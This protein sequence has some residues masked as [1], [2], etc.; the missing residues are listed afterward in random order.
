MAKGGHTW[1]GGDRA[2]SLLHSKT[3]L[4]ATGTP[5]STAKSEPPQLAVCVSCTNILCKYYNT[6]I[7]VSHSTQ[8]GPQYFLCKWMKSYVKVGW[9]W[10][11][12]KEHLWGLNYV[13]FKNHPCLVH[14][15]TRMKNK[16]MDCGKS[17][18]IT[19]WMCGHSFMC[20]CNSRFTA[21]SRSNMLRSCIDKG[22][23]HKLQGIKTSS[24]STKQRQTN[25]GWGLCADV[26]H[27]W[28]QV[29]TLKTDRCILQLFC[30]V[31]CMAAFS[32]TSPQQSVTMH[33]LTPSTF[34]PLWSSSFKATTK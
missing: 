33:R 23:G 17:Q 1:W 27:R 18:Q 7:N 2:C 13:H 6:K 19:I 16:V 8:D 25:G 22:S 5:E 34:I 20:S 28:A 29:T 31:C 14:F 15:S 10:I 30:W 12:H 9:K 24:N 21:S 11:I 4:W 32:P 26:S 3:M